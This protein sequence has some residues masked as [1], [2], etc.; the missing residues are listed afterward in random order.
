MTRAVDLQDT[1]SKTQAVER[2]FKSLQQAPELDQRQFAVDLK[3]AIDDKKEQVEETQKDE[4][5]KI[6]DEKNK[7][8]NE[9]TY[10]HKEESKEQ[11]PEV[12]TGD[13]EQKSSTDHRI[14]M[15]V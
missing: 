4:Y 1:L 10:E 14:D 15:K 8:P 3:R 9:D 11:E 13:I 6:H 2:V 12:S 7:Q 5:T